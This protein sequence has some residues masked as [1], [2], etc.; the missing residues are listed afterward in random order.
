MEKIDKQQ[1]KK[2]SGGTVALIA[3]GCFLVGGLITFLLWLAFRK[4]K[5]K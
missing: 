3:C 2:L 4:K 1:P 5:V